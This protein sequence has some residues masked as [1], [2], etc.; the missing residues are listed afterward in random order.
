MRHG[1]GGGRT[2]PPP[3][4]LPSLTREK[5]RFWGSLASYARASSFHCATSPQ[6]RHF[7]KELRETRAPKNTVFGWLEGDDDGDRSR[8]SHLAASNLAYLVCRGFWDRWASEVALVQVVAPLAF[9][10][11]GFPGVPAV[12]HREVHVSRLVYGLSG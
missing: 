2:D 11:I 7:R 4:E 10:R 5:P 1:R 3:R 8:C 6:T 12:C 9:D